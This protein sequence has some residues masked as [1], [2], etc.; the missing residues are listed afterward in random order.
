MR[1]QSRAERDVDPLDIL[2]APPEN[3]TPA[4]RELRLETEREA[5]KR[6]DLI[7]EEINKQRIAEKKAP[8]AVKLLLLGE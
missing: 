4:E 5:K 1:R 2:M 3:E 6:S 8:K 7:D